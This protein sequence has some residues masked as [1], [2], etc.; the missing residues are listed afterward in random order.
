MGIPSTGVMKRSRRMGTDGRV[1]E[2]LKKETGARGY[3]RRNVECGRAI[4]WSLESRFFHE[5]NDVR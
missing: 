5:K 3:A 2:L 1:D 4:L